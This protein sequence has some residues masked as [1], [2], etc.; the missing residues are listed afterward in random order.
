MGYIGMCRCEGLWDRLYKS[1][2]LGSA[3]GVQD[4]GNFVSSAKSV[5]S[6]V[7]F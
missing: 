1:D 2:S 4:G 6:S 3:V 7:F 5:V